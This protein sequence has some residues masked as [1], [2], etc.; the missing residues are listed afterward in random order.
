MFLYMIEMIFSLYPLF[1][2][3]KMDMDMDMD[4]DTDTELKLHC[5]WRVIDA[6]VSAHRVA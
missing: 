2:P 5:S 4:T 3:K 1:K 6:F